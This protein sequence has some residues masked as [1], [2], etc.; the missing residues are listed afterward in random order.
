[1][2]KDQEPKPRIK[3]DGAVPSILTRNQGAKSKD[4][5]PRTC[6]KHQGPGSRNGIIQSKEHTLILTLCPEQTKLQ[7]VM[8][9]CY[10]VPRIHREAYSYNVILCKL[11]PGQWV[12]ATRVFVSRARKA[13]C[14]AITW[15]LLGRTSSRCDMLARMMLSI[16]YNILCIMAILWRILRTASHQYSIRFAIPAEA[17]GP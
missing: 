1:M 3:H 11:C 8:E 16:I 12:V 4:Q 5:E 13:L 10:P 9:N 14:V 6:T 15:N 7:T 2:A 17:L